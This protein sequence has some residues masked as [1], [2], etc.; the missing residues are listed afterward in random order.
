MEALFGDDPPSTGELDGDGQAAL[1]VAND[2]ARRGTRKTTKRKPT[3]TTDA[4]APSSGSDVRDVSLSG[5]KR[6]MAEFK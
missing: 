4:V 5:V 2:N 1:V 6:V 3:G